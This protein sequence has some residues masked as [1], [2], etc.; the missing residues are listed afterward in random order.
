MEIHNLSKHPSLLNHFVE[1]LRDVEVQ[2]DRERFRKNVERI[3]SV[4]AYEISKQLNYAQKS[5]QTPL[6]VSTSDLLTEQ[7]IIATILRAGIPLQQGINYFFNQAD[8]AYI[9]AF[10][11]YTEGDKFEVIVE[12]LATP[13]IEDRVLI[14]ADP[15][16]ASGL[17]LDLCHKALLNTGK[18]KEVHIVCVIASQR[19]VDYV[20]DNISEGH[21]WIACIDDE[22]NK[23][24]YI[25]PGLGDAGDLSFGEKIQM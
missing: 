19:G 22:L 16:L 3:G 9:S 4:M 17:S 20:M 24:G 21:L 13:P 10:R 6:G 15:M 2:K 7:P 12:Y 5:T 14:I 23:H 8:L 25:V 1:E 18:P 11:R